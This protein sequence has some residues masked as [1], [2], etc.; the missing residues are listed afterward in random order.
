[1]PAELT[2]KE[3]IDR[4]L[5]GDDVDRPPF[6]LWNH[7]GLE[8]F[9]GERHAQATLDFHRRYRTD[10][11]KVMSD[12]P[13]PKPDGWRAL[14]VEANP[15]PEQIR[16]L[17]IIRDRLAGSMYFIETIFNPYN[18]AQKTFSKDEVARMRREDP[19]TLLDALEVIAESEANHARRA[20]QAGASGIFLA[21]DNAIE[22]VLTREEYARFSEPFD[23]MVLE[24]AAG[25][26]LNVLHLHGDKVYLDLFFQ[27]WPAAGISYSAHATGV[28]IAEVRSRYS[29]LIM[30][31]IDERNYRT[32]TE[33]EI[34]RQWREAQ[35]A[36]GKRF[37]LAPGCSVP[38]ESTEE[39]LSRLAL[40]VGA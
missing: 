20:L 21:I 29:G 18:Q 15:F 3:R 38:D 34:R 12:F 9:P 10:L 7:F 28:S 39:E 2:S 19:Q 37:L 26:P 36:A 5:R 4:A 6:T 33:E 25:A 32:L 35:Q 16:A 30:A 1:M 11:V 14:K 23:R 40:A 17:E 13:Y 27:G 31:G 8:K 22:G 24:A